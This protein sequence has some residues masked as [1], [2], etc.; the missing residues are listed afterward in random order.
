MNSEKTKIK[1][2]LS[3]EIIYEKIL[4][5]IGLESKKEIIQILEEGVDQDLRKELQDEIF[6]NLH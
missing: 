3:Q 6:K 5:I 1:K 2:Q 4:K